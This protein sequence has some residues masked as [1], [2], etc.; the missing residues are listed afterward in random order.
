M[1]MYKLNLNESTHACVSDLASMAACMAY[2]AK[3][4]HLV[5][6]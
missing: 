6:H 4:A 5:S 1:Y 3:A 2:V